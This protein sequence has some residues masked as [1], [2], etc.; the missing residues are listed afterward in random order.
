[1]PAKESVA[2]R[3]PTWESSRFLTA[4]ASWGARPLL[5]WSNLGVS[6]L[7]IVI[8]SFLVPGLSLP[9]ALLAIVLGSLVGNEARE[10]RA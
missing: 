1:M 7:V 3:V 6:L 5:L 8:G 9:D 10:R 4:S 2:D